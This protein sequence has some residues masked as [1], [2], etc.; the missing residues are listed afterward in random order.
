[1]LRF[2][3]G[4]EL[5]SAAAFFE[6]QPLPLGRRIAIVSNSP[7]VATL[8]ADAC[9]AQGLHVSTATDAENPRVLP[10]GAGPDEYAAAVREL[11]ADPGVDSLLV[12]YVDRHG[13][14]PEA[15]LRA[16]TAAST[17]ASKPV[18]ACVVRA[19]GRLPARTRSDVPN[20]LFPESCARG[21]RARGA[22]ASPGYRGRLANGPSIAT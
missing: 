11:L 7:S 19:D 20:F 13:G 10:L 3:S 22:T 17:V 15:I 16:I 1:M 8:A 18:V 4:E 6:S 5:F 2:Q 21:A 14:D 9:T 12:G